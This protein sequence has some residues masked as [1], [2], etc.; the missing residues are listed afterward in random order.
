MLEGM[1]GP[2]QKSARVNIYTDTFLIQG[3]LSYVGFLQTYLSDDTRDTIQ[4]TNVEVSA[5][6]PDNPLARME[7]EELTLQKD[8]MHLIAFP[9]GIS[10]EDVALLTREEPTVIYTSRYAIQCTLHISPDT[11]ISDFVG[12][13]LSGYQ[14]CANMTLYPL[15]TP[16]QPLPD[17]APVVLIRAEYIQLYHP[18]K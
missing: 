5:L 16:R 12:T 9:D 10:T 1:D 4:V 7:I 11:R 13:L 15:F 17:Q 2:R 8:G 6:L 14:A 3:N 18:F